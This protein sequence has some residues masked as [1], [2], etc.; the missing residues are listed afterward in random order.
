MSS[1]DIHLGELEQQQLLLWRRRVGGDP[2]NVGQAILVD[3]A[4]SVVVGVMPPGVQVSDD[5]GVVCW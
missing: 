5:R 1:S 2:S 4:P 3:G